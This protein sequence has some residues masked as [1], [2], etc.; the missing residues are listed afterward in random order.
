LHANWAQVLVETGW[1]GLA[2]YLAWMGLALWDGGAWVR[3]TGCAEGSLRG[4][5]RV[6][7]ALLVGLLLN[8][9]VEY[10]FG[11]TELM[12]IYAFVMGLIGIAPQAEA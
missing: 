9:L 5:P 10:N 2:L 4:P 8:G 1:M 7:F 11:D 12:F 3:R 6:V